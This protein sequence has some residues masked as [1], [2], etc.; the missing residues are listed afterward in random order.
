MT[1][2]YFNSV[3]NLLP[4]ILKPY[5]DL[6]GLDVRQNG[7]LSDQ[8]LSS[9]GAG[10]GALSIDSFKRVHLLRGVPDILSTVSKVLVYASVTAVSVLSQRHRHF[11]RWEKGW[12]KKEKQTHQLDNQNRQ[13]ETQKERRS[14]FSGISF[15]F[16]LGLMG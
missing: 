11:H 14:N 4:A 12:G 7:A 2:S 1:T 10:L 15:L 9:Q 3:S 6:L 16:L 5:F 8:L 13:Q